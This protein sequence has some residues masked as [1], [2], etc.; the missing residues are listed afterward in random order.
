M[1]VLVVV[2]ISALIGLALYLTVTTYNPSADQ[3]IVRSDVAY[4]GGAPR[5]EEIC[6]YPDIP[7]IRVWG[8]GLAY[9]R[10]IVTAPMGE[11]RYSRLSWIEMEEVISGLWLHGLFTDF[12][13]GAPNPAG[14]S[15]EISVQVLLFSHHQD[16][17]TDIPP[18]SG[19]LRAY[20][21]LVGYLSSK[22][23]V[24][25]PGMSGEPRIDQLNIDRGCSI[26]SPAP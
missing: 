16:L 18:R 4:R 12:E 13:V 3:E 24:F 21:W 25:E 8:D 22:L 15:H 23:T 26:P 5:P 10:A 1:R 14:D 19:T 20:K 11:S 7:E 6:I 2:L 9:Y 17:L